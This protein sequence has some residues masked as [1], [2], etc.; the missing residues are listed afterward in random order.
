ML[1]LSAFAG[2]AAPARDIATAAKT[3]NAVTSIP[4]PIDMLFPLELLSGGVCHGLA[5]IV[6]HERP[7][8]GMHFPRE[9]PSELV[10]GIRH[11]RFMRTR[12]RE[13]AR[14]RRVLLVGVRH[15]R[16]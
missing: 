16:R 6:R 3:N 12:E 1:C 9:H 10:V 7:D 13:P 15:V 2:S 14:E 5:P 11:A 4:R 8:G